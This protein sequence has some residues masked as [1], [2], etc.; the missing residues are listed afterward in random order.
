MMYYAIPKQSKPSR[1]ERDSF[2]HANRLV[3]WHPLALSIIALVTVLAGSP[4]FLVVI[5]NIMVGLV[6]CF[7]LLSLFLVMALTA[8]GGNLVGEMIWDN[9]IP[10]A[11]RDV[12]LCFVN[13]FVCSFILYV[14]GLIACFS[15]FGVMFAWFVFHIVS[16]IKFRQYTH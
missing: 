7:I 3:V 5:A 2:E 16:W 14:S 13:F 1:S 11:Q 9:K 4:T 10:I 15:Y 6:A 12:Q 8:R